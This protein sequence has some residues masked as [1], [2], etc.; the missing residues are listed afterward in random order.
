MLLHSLNCEKYSNILLNCYLGWGISHLWCIRHCSVRCNMFYHVC[1]LT[2]R[3]ITNITNKWFFSGVDFKMLLK[4][5]PFAVYQ[6]TTNRAT[7]VFRP[8]IIHVKVEIFQVSSYYV[9]LDTLNRPMVI[10]DFHLVIRDNS[11]ISG[12]WLPWW[13]F[14]WWIFLMWNMGTNHFFLCFSRRWRWFWSRRWWW[15]GYWMRLLFS[16]HPLLSWFHSTVN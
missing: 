10:L 9:T 11:V 7:L 15:W 8:M 4:V 13:F 6:E 14:V 16:F 12:S 1:L 2:E 5:E 3:S